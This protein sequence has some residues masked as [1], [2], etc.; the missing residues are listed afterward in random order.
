MQRYY[1]KISILF[2]LF[3]FF[4]VAVQAQIVNIEEGRMGRDSSNHVAGQIGL[5]FSLYNQNAGRNQPNNYLQLTFKGDLAYNTPKH[6]YLFLNYFNYLL[7]NFNVEAQRNT[8]AQQGYSHLRANLYQA[9]RLSY[10]LF[11][12]AQADKARG[13]EWRTLEG[14]YLRFR[15]MRQ[16]NKNINVFLGAGA[17]HEHEEW[18]NP[19]LAQQLQISNLVKWTSYVS[20]KFN[21][22]KN[23]QA[24]AITYYQVGYSKIIAAFRNRVSGDISLA[25]TLNKTLSFKTSFNCTYEDRPIVP[26]TKFVYTLANGIA[27][28]F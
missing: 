2:F 10:E 7:V 16:E 18:E 4:A 24:N 21:I 17:M 3:I 13:L 14:G 27:V 15:L 11:A 19:E 9:R 1:Y 25:V 5:D 12:Q 8:V 20:A 22:D 26:V 6:T 23:I 28:N